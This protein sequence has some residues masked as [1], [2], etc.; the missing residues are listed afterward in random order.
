MREF[1]EELGD[2]LVKDVRY[3]KGSSLHDHMLPSEM[4]WIGSESW[5]IDPNDPLL[6]GFRVASAV[7]GPAAWI[8]A[9]GGIAILQRR[10]RI[11]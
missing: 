7:P 8:T 11:C 4:D 3:T 2:P 1:T 9:L 10:R 6:V 5:T